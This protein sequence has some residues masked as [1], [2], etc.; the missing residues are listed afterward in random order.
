MNGNRRGQTLRRYSAAGDCRS[1]FRGINT[2]S[3]RNINFG[4]R[5]ACT[6]GLQ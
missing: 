4:I 3:T 6:A 5:L 1:A 2:P